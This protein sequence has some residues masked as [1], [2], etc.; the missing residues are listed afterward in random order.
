MSSS[1]CSLEQNDYSAFCTFSNLAS[2][3]VANWA[4]FL[5]TEQLTKERKRR[6]VLRCG[7]RCIKNVTL[8]LIACVGSKGANIHPPFTLCTVLIVLEYCTV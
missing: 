7:Y 4:Q 3:D 2:L 1:G 6:S 5:L 8:F